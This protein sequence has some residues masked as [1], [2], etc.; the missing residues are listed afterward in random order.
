MEYNSQCRPTE[1]GSYAFY[2]CKS[3][4]WNALNFPE[5]VNTIDDYAF[6]NCEKFTSVVIKPHITKFGNYVFTGCTSVTGVTIEE[7]EEA[8]SLGHGCSKGSG[9]GLFNDC[10]LY[11]V[12]I[13]RPLSYTYFVNNE[14]TPFTGITSLEKARL[15]K[16][17]TV[18]RNYLFYG[19]THLNEVTS[20]AV[21]PP[22]AN[23]NCFANY[24]ATLYVPKGSVTA[25]K[26]AAV[27]KDFYSII[28]VD[29]VDSML[30]DIDGNG[31]INITD[32]TSLIDY[33]LTGN[34]SEINTTNADVN[35]DGRINIT[36]VTD[37]I[38][39]LLSGQ[40]N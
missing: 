13:G 31:K 19:C 25:Y 24:D 35:G 29:I 32:V 23:T 18:V 20:C 30:G 8:L 27:W 39:Y 2:G 17:L 9:Y 1:I 26:N 21:T 3:L 16:K 6:G 4:T 12:F 37:L 36:D 33:L 34:A 22:T 14:F 7:S 15:G 5:S 28:G 11:S 40:W 10:P 38:D